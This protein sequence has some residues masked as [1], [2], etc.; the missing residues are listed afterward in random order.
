MTKKEIRER[1]K[2]ELDPHR[3]SH[4]MGVAKTARKLAVRYGADPERAY[5]AGLLHDCAKNVPKE[6]RIGTAERYGVELSDVERRNTSLIHAK[7]GAAMA[8]RDYGVEDQ[9]I[10]SAIRWHTVGRPGM[11]LLEEIVYVADFIEP[12]R[13]KLPQLD[14]LRELAYEDLDECVVRM[15]ESSFSYLRAQ[16]REIDPAGMETYQYYKEKG[17]A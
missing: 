11:T 12:T 4:T 2:E 3:Y 6:D 10:L 15:L 9:E 13:K 7:L 8:K 17:T 16:G 1:L 5:L 14:E